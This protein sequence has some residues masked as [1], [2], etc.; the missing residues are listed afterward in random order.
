VGGPGKSRGAFAG[1]VLVVA[2]LCCHFYVVYTIASQPLDINRHPEAFRSVIWP[3]HNDT[4]HR[5]GPGADFFAVYHAGQALRRGSSPYE[6]SEPA[7]WT[8]YF[9]P[10]RYLPISAQTLGLFFSQLPPR[11]AYLLWICFLELLLGVLIYTFVRRTRDERLKYFSAGI[12]LVASR[13][14]PSIRN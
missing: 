4:V 3:L 8:P 6:S 9:H 11:V 14:I 7:R 1:R 10:F 5:I 12:L 13:R 2:L